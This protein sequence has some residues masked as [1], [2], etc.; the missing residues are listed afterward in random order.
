MKKANKDYFLRSSVSP[1]SPS[2]LKE[3]GSGIA[4]WVRQKL[5][6][7]IVGTFTVKDIF[8]VSLT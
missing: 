6:F 3:A 5:K 4:S 7:P 8:R 1:P 2:R